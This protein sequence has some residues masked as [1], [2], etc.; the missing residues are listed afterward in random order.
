V[1]LTKRAGGVRGMVVGD[2]F[3]RL[4]AKTIAKQHSSSL[5]AACAPFQFA[6]STPAG[7]ECVAHMVQALTQ[8]DAE[9]TV[10]SI[11]GVGAFDHAKRRSMLDGL[12]GAGDAANAVPF[13][14]MFYGEASEFLRTDD[15]GVTHSI[16]QGEGGEQ[17]DPL[18][19]ALYSL[20]QHPALAEVASELLEGEHLF[21]FLD[22]VYYVC[23]P[24]RVAALF[25]KVSEALDKHAGISVNLG[26]TKVWNAAGKE[27]PQC[28]ELGD[29][30][31]TPWAG[32]PALP[33]EERG[34]KM[35]GTPLGSDEYVAEFLADLRGDHD[36][37]LDRLPSM[38]DLQ[39]A[40]LILLFCGATRANYVL[41]TVAPTSSA[42]F[43]AQHDEAIWRPF[44][45]ML[46]EAPNGEAE[47]I[48]RAIAQLPL[49]KGGLG[50]RSAART[51]PAAWWASW[52]DALPI[53]KAKVPE[54]AAAITRAMEDEAGPP[55]RC[56]QERCAAR[57]LL[58]AEGF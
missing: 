46:G 58:A 26:K 24:D 55:A 38:D 40:W 5:D 51:A 12:L 54:L 9:A 13:V 19:P 22:D 39:A 36:Q 2:L 17:G 49:R 47:D 37:L 25:H 14:K 10:V 11:D 20:G 8:L 32:D 57:D 6:L 3:R 43:A 4:V 34:I 1:A 33:A 42:G 52:A 45:R 53:I 15:E 27:P 48:A 21:A 44:K 29:G 30:S 16:F 41:R 31:T 18:M 35:L 56:L 7:T 23:T 28:S 50:L